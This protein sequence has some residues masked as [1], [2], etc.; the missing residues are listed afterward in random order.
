MN[1]YQIKAIR[2]NTKPPIWRRAFV[3]DNIT[4]TQLAI[5]LQK[6]LDI[7]ETPSYEFE[8]YASKIR[9]IEWDDTEDYRG[10][11][12]YSYI[13][14]QETYINDYLDNEKWFNFKTDVKAFPD[15]TGRNRE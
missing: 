7:P 12:Y 4:F 6:L 3:P 8:F 15:V 11:Y 2:K 9:F 1:F 5:V 14:A 13:S 10:D